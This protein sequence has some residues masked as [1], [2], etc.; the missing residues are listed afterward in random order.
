MKL[1][2]KMLLLTILAPCIAYA[3]F[4]A[5]QWTATTYRDIGGTDSY[6]GL[7]FCI[8]A[9]GKWYGTNE[10]RGQGQ[11]AQK[12][13]AIHLHLN[14]V[15]SYG[16]YSESIELNV[17]NPSFLAGYWQEWETNLAYNAYFTT[18]WTFVSATCN[19]PA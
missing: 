8:Q 9:N 19:P 6:P 13:N 2:K 18:E 3:Q 7:G 17:I 16:S 1:F 5:G 11:W 15:E 4:P 14:R 12:G 10:V